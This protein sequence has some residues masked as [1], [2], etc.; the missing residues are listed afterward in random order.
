MAESHSSRSTHQISKIN[1]EGPSSDNTG[2]KPMRNEPLINTH[3]KKQ[4]KGG[5]RCRRCGNQRGLIRKV[6]RR[7]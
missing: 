6:R 2:E 7:V 1:M 3:P 4:S 5:R